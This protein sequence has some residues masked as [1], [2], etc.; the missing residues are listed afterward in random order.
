[1][2][3]FYNREFGICA[4]MTIDLNLIYDNIAEIL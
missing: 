3:F 2:S 1:M 4:I